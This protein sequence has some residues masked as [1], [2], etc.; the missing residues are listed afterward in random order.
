MLAEAKLG[1]PIDLRLVNG[2]CYLPFVR[3]D[4]EAE[5]IVKSEGCAALQFSAYPTYPYGGC[6]GWK[7]CDRVALDK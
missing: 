6:R 3:S 7:N 5:Q 1:A 4:E 2:A